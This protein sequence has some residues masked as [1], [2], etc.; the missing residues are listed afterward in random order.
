MV[1]DF[2]LWGRLAGF[3]YCKKRDWELGREIDSLNR[4]KVT[5][6]FMST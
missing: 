3:L 1:V 5:D 2:L 4:I 6:R